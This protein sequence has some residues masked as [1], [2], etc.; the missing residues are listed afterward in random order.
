MTAYCIK[1]E[2]H[3]WWSESGGYV[4]DHTQA[5]KLDWEQAR[6]AKQ[7]LAGTIVTSPPEMVGRYVTWEEVETP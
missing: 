7:L 4:K 3:G 5:V 6:R 1:H 2:Q